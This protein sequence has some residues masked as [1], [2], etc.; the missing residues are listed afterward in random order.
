[1][2]VQAVSI[3]NVGKQKSVLLRPS[4]KKIYIDPKKYDSDQLIYTL[5]CLLSREGIY[6]TQMD[7][8]KYGYVDK[9]A[10]WL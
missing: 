6:Y 1:M 5:E 10:S 2:E 7:D 8:I 9:E 4:N 3:K